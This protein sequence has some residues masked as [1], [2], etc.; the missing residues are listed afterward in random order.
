MS[1]VYFTGSITSVFITRKGQCQETFSPFFL[2]HNF[3][4]PNRYACKG[5]LFFFSNVCSDIHIWSHS[6]VYSS[7]GSH[8]RYRAELFTN[9]LEHAMTFR[10]TIIPNKLHT[11]LISWEYVKIKN[12]AYNYFLCLFW[13]TVFI[14]S[15][16]TSVCRACNLTSFSPCLTGP[17]DYPFASRHKGPG[18]KPQGDT[19]VKP[20]FSC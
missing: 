11:P 19:N 5:F 6:L 1:R 7:Q 3:P 14:H 15:R 10:G 20:G 18:F 12:G 9:F 16:M 2:S 4:G 13:T 17:V 8:F